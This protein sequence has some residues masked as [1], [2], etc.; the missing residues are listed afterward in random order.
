MRMLILKI[1]NFLHQGHKIQAIKHH[2]QITGYGLKDSKEYIDNL[3]FQHKDL[4]RI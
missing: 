2:R 4:L 3:C 1:I